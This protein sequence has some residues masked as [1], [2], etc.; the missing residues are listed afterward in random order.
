MKNALVLGSLIT[1]T[2]ALAW[3][4]ALEACSSSSSSPATTVDAGNEA[5]TDAPANTPPPKSGTPT[6]HRTAATTCGKTRPA[7]HAGDAGSDAG[8]DPC[9]VDGDCVAGK[10][11]RCIIGEAES[12][13]TCSYDECYADSDCPSGDV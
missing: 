2:F 4:A 7:G 10:N 1:S 5:A 12:T 11:G 6:Y 13:G 3:G 8:M 9:M